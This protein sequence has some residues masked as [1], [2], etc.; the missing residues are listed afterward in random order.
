MS[1]S[2]T[3]LSVTFLMNMM[4]L[5]F[6]SITVFAYL[7]IHH[8]YKKFA[9]ESAPIRSK[10]IKSQKMILKNEVEKAISYIYYKNSLTEKRL[11]QSV[12]GRVYEAH[13][14][15]ENIYNENRNIKNDTEIKKIIKD[16]LRPIR[17]NHGR[18]Y[19]YALSLN[20][21]M[22]LLANRPEREGKDVSETQDIHGRYITR[23]VIRIIRESGEGF[24]RYN[25]TKPNAQGRGFPKIAFI[26]YFKP[27]DWLI[28]TGEYLDDVNNDIQTEVLER[29]ADIRFG[30]HGYLFGST[31]NGDPLFTNG[32]IT[33]GSNSVW[34]L[35]DPNGVRI[36]REQRKIAEN[37]E[38]GFLNYSW[39]KLTHPD[40]LPKVSFIKGVPEWGW[41]IGTGAYIDE[42]ENVIARKKEELRQRIKTYIIRIIFTLAVLLMFNY[43]IAK[44][45]SVRLKKSFD[46]FSSF[47]ESAAYG[48]MIINPDLLDYSEFKNM[49]VSANRMTEERRQAEKALAGS[50]DRYRLIFEHSPLGI[51]HFDRNSVIRDCNKIFAEIIG[52][53]R[54]KLIGFNMLKSMKDSPARSA[55]ED[56]IRHGMGHFEGK[57]T[58]VSGN[59]EVV[60]R[61]T[62]KSITTQNG[63]FYGAVGVF[64]DITE[65]K[66]AEQEL[67]KMKNYLDNILNSSPS[68][69]IGTDAQGNIT[70]FNP[71]AETL[72]GFSMNDVQGKKLID[73]MPEYTEDIRQVMQNKVSLTREKMQNKYGARTGYN[74]I[75]IYPLIADGLEGTVLRI[76]DVTERVR[77][78]EMMV[79][80]EKMMSVGGLAAGMAHEINNPLGGIVQSTQNILRRISHELPKNKQIAHDCGTELAVILSYLEKREIVRFLEGIRQSGKRASNIVA[81]M[82]S[83]SRRSESKK[84]FADISEILDNTIELAAHDYDLKKK[85]DFRNIEIV[86]DFAPDLPQLI[87]TVTEIEQVVLN[88]LRNSAQAMAGKTGAEPPRITLRVREGRDT[89]CIE[90]EDNGPGMDEKVRKRVFEPFFTTKEVGIGTGLGL[91]VSYF[92]ITT[93]HNGTMTVESAPGKGARFVIQ[94]PLA[95]PAAS[96]S[97]SHTDM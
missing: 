27:Y 83:F 25:W 21:T 86:R 31:Y 20:G 57:Y 61:A 34:N 44:Y 30:E 68:A 77:F 12:K 88:L 17:F 60:I 73:I 35:T 51:M 59:K 49:A 63:E 1:K 36:T 70:T 81:N 50:Q 43:L 15:A 69:I 84:A 82:L 4:A 7:W 93:N 13:S 8:E 16:A 58:T 3:S 38:G 45:I 40:P 22:E 89:I 19:Y 32:K 47:F 26:K 53:P 23:D 5:T 85:Y 72:S 33:R 94:L 74:N 48:H 24:Y 76:D 78:E 11:R 92:I 10:Y 65:R 80:T 18:G 6:I 75:Y 87:C 46:T 52:A 9:E 42:I 41:M 90:T 54:E 29:L 56:A 39:K 37:P 67:R 71:A 97:P 79:Q 66:K 91:S 62:H 95:G 28:G 64:E 55:V 96:Y 14:I 2:K